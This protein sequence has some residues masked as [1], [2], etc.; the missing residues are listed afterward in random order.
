MRSLFRA[1]TGRPNIAAPAWS[2]NPSLLSGAVEGAS[3]TCAPGTFSGA[4]VS[5]TYQWQ[6]SATEGGTYTNI[7]GATSAT[8]GPWATGAT[9][10][11]RCR[12]TLTDRFGRTASF[13]TSAVEVQA[14]GGSGSASA[15]KTGATEITFTIT[16]A[17]S[18]MAGIE[19]GVSP[20]YTWVAFSADAAASHTI[21]ITAFDGLEV[22]QTVAWRAYVT[23]DPLDA[24]TSRTYIGTPGTIAL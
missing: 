19:Y 9:N 13:D 4:S 11:K 8:Y 15:I 6:E 10:W 23:A 14:S 7:V 2:V 3:T 1:A 20:A 5:I 18:A 17:A 21:I 16:P 12:V 22:G 24:P